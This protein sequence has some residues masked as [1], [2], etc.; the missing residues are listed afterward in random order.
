MHDE[1]VQISDYPGT[2]IICGGICLVLS[3]FK[4]SLVCN[5]F[6]RVAPV[7]VYFPDM[8]CC[9]FLDCLMAVCD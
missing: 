9:M 8:S 5:L 6:M 4:L 1:C 3:I 7:I 2:L